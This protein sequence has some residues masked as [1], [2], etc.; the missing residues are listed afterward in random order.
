VS[1]Y[2]ENITDPLKGYGRKLRAAR[3]IVRR[4]GR[5]Y[6]SGSRNKVWVGRYERACAFLVRDALEKLTD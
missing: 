1:N 3:Y 6:D 4:Y 2:I 5:D